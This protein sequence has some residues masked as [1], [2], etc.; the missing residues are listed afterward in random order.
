MA[1]D[2]KEEEY[3]ND[4]EDAADQDDDEEED[5]STTQDLRNRN[6]HLTI[7]VDEDLVDR[8]RSR[9]MRPIIQEYKNEALNYSYEENQNSENEVEEEVEDENKGKYFSDHFYWK[10]QMDMNDMNTD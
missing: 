6:H 5:L 10:T 3:V 4:E 1:Y 9:S 2:Y 8:A 7:Q